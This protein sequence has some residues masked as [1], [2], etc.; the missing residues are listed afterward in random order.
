MNLYLYGEK[1][2]YQADIYC[3]DSDETCKVYCGSASA[4]YYAEVIYSNEDE[5][6]LY[7]DDCGDYPGTVNGDGVYCP[8]LTLY[9]AST[10]D[11]A[12]IKAAK[13]ATVEASHDYTF[14][15]SNIEHALE[16]E[17]RARK[18]NDEKREAAIAIID[19]DRLDG[20][21]NVPP[22][23]DNDAEEHKKRISEM[24]ELNVASISNYGAQHVTHPLT[25]YGAIGG[26]L[27]AVILMLIYSKCSNKNSKNEYQ[28]L[29]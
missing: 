17:V 2:G 15:E 16:H 21:D 27:I 26:G 20:E 18:E 10:T 6:D 5:L 23:N 8:T 12:A 19:Q 1:A 22:N 14:A 25:I 13:K 11:I 7:P 28:P 9:D 24:K 3:L 4:C 29:L